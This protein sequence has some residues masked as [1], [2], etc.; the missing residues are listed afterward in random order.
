MVGLSN[1]SKKSANIASCINVEHQKNT[2]ERFRTGHIDLVIATTVLEEGI[3]VPACNIVICFDE[4]MNL[5]SFVQRRGR[6]RHRDSKLV[7][8]LASQSDKLRDLQKLEVE[9]KAIYENQM[10]VLRETAILEDADTELQR[11]FRIQMTG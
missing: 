5:K 3:D 11:E 6:A 10:R 8:M 2:V 1:N 9:M 4:D 7:I